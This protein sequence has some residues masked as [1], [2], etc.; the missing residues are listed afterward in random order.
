MSVIINAIDGGTASNSFVTMEQAQ[1]YFDQRLDHH[2][3]NELPQDSKARYLIAA[4]DLINSLPL[5]DGLISSEYEQAL[6]YP[7]YGEV[8]T[9]NQIPIEGM[10][11][12]A[13]ES[14]QEST[15]V[16][17]LMT[18][19]VTLSIRPGSYHTGATY[20]PAAGWGQVGSVLTHATL[21]TESFRLVLDQTKI[22][23]NDM[24]GFSL[25]INAPELQTLAGSV[26]VKIGTYSKV[27]QEISTLGPHVFELEAVNIDYVIFTPTSDF[28]GVISIN[29]ITQTEAKY[30]KVIAVSGATYAHFGVGEIYRVTVDSVTGSATLYEG[31]NLLAAFSSADVPLV[32]EDRTNSAEELWIHNANDALLDIVFKVEHVSHRESIHAAEKATILQAMWMIKNQDLIDISLEGGI[33]GYT[34]ENYGHGSN[35]KAMVGTNPYKRFGPG[36]LGLMSPYIQLWVGIR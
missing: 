30:E 16:V 9:P 23:D 2:R 10:V 18:G 29:S 31:A 14:L 34:K 13:P 36:V 3:W 1:K 19:K 6:K 20:M 21:T 4:T 24:V 17:D 15:Y 11:V 27:I 33:T 28:N 26:S 35:E 7:L 25:D 12:E 32:T 5:R 22:A 8:G